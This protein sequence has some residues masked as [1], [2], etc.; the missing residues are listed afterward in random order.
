MS[1][2]TALPDLDPVEGTEDF[3]AFW[4]QLDRKGKV[5]TIMGERVT[6]PPAIPLQFE[7]EAKRVQRSKK[8]EDIKRLVAILF[9]DGT[10]KRWSEKGMDQHQFMV[11]LA[12]APRVIAGVPVTLA[13]VDAEVRAA[14]TGEPDPT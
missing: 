5:T 1:E 8:P 4:D 12:W 13:E 9:G 6:L 3:D 10:L 2:N 14:V 11:L 7:L